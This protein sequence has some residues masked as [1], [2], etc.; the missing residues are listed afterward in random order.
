MFRSS[1]LAAILIVD[2]QATAPVLEKPVDAVGN[3]LPRQSVE[4]PVLRHTCD[5]G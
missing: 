5:S 1:L 2:V 3:G 4:R